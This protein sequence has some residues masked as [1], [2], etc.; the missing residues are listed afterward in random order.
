M[1]ALAFVFSLPPFA[2]P[3]HHHHHFSEAQKLTIYYCVPLGSALC[4]RLCAQHPVHPILHPTHPVH[5]SH[6]THPTH[7]A[8]ST[9]PTHSA[10]PTHIILRILLN[11]RILRI[12][13]ILRVLCTLRTLCILSI[14]PPPDHAQDK[15]VSSRLRISAFALQHYTSEF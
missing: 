7:S 11:L 3:G 5:P 8:H 4:N 6:P 13:P 14:S 15:A 9:H 12:L 10:H 2:L 1:L